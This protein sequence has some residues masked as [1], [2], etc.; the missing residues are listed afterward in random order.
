MGWM[1]GLGRRILGFVRMEGFGALVGKE[2]VPAQF[3]SEEGEG[4]DW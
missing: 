2:V 1:L 3:T 4:R